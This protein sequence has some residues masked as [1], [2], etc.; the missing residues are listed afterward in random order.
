MKTHVEPSSLAKSV[1]WWSKCNR[2]LWVCS[3]NLNQRVGLF[4]ELIQEA[5]INVTACVKSM[6]IMI[7]L[8]E[9]LFWEILFS[10]K[11][12]RSNVFALDMV[13]LRWTSIPSGVYSP[14]LYPVHLLSHLR[15]T[16]LDRTFEI[17]CSM[18]KM[19][20]IQSKPLFIHIK[21]Q[22]KEIHVQ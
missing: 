14:F 12:I 18:H 1:N 15:L 5:L 22:D 3:S 13:R 11:F 17:F 8:S 2:V 7:R 10:S 16:H 19:T 20:C 21:W 4:I 6:R 9:A